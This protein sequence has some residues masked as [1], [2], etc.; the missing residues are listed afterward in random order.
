MLC[1]GIRRGKLLRRVGWRRG[2]GAVESCGLV[3]V[4]RRK[5]AGSGATDFIWAG[6]GSFVVK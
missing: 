1:C 3:G 2:R 4:W 5:G 6:A